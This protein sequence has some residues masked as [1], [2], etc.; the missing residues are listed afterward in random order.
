[1]ARHARSLEIDDDMT[2]HR[3]D[4][5][6]ERVGWVALWAIPVLALTGLLGPGPLGSTR[7]EAPGGLRVTYPAIARADAPFRI[8]A[9]LPAP[10]AGSPSALFIAAPL[11]DRLDVES[12]TPE[13]VAVASTSEGSTFEFA[14]SAPRVV[15]RA[16]TERSGRLRGEVRAG[17]TA[18]TISSTVLP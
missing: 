7:I 10:E 2:F 16:K 13:P 1:M 4:W 18:V 6:A 3:R 11:L 9:D 14:G 17:A 8:E 5:I 15:V 12:V